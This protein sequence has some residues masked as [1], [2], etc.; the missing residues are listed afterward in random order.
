M[1]Y[2]SVI[3]DLEGTLEIPGTMAINSKPSGVVLQEGVLDG[4]TLLGEKYPLFIVSN[5]SARMLERFLSFSDMRQRFRD[6]ECLGN[7]GYGKSENIIDI[8]KRNQLK[9]PIYIGD[10][11]PDA[12][13]AHA[14]KVPYIH[15]A[16]GM[17]GWLDGAQN[18][19][20]FKEIADYL[21]S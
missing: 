11:Y 12:D 6:W 7:S 8:V 10:S 1:K 20:T 15:A 2:D 4:L 17:D 3:L 13:A 5:C 19:E 21:I 14:A 9:R 16:Y 18:F